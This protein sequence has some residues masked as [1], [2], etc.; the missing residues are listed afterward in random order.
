MLRKILA[1]ILI[2]HSFVNGSP[3]INNFVAKDL[4]FETKS[5]NELK[6]E[7]L[8]LIDFWAT[9][10]K[11]CIQ[12]IPKL[13]QLRENYKEKGLEIIGINTD[14]PRNSAKVKAFTKTHNINYPIL[15][16]TNS[17]IART[18]NVSAFPTLFIVNSAN[19]IVYTHTGFKIGDEKIIEAE[20]EKLLNEI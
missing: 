16:D 15:R 19:E 9:W 14:S 17:N 3:K 18:L 6:G 1:L 12:A 10:C 5:F 7:K 8:T 13:R 2:S 4:N 11:P 20:I